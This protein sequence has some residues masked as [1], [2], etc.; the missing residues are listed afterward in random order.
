MLSRGS[1]ARDVSWWAL[2]GAL[3][4]ALRAEAAPLYQLRTFTRRDGLAHDIVRDVLEARDGA[5]WFATPEGVT[6][7]D[8]LRGRYELLRPSQAETTALAEGPDG[9]IWIGT[10][11]AGLGRYRGGRWRWFTRRDGLPSD[12]VKSLLVDR[13]GRLWATLGGG[14][15]IRGDGERLFAYGPAQGLAPGELTRCTELRSG[16]IVCGVHDQ[17]LLQRF[18]GQR[19][20]ALPVRAEVRRHF[21]VQALAEDRD[22]RLWLGTAGAGALAGLLREGSYHFEVYDARRGLASNRVLAIRPARDGRLWLA[23]SGGASRFDGRT[24]SS[25]TRRDGLGSNLILALAEARDGAIWMGTLGGGVTRHAL[26]RWEQMTEADGLASN[27]L[28]GGLLRSRDGALWVGTDGGVCRFAQGRWETFRTGHPDRDY[29][30]HLLEDRRGI[31]WVATRAGIRRRDPD[32][33]WHDEALRPGGRPVGV[34]HLAQTPA[35]E[36]WLATGAGV[37]ARGP[38]GY[39]WYARDRG[40]PAEEANA[41]LVDRGGRV[42]VATDG[43]VARLEN[44]RWIAFPTAPAPERADRVFG[45]AQARDGGLW[46][47]GPSGVY[48]LRGDKWE[49]LPSGPF[50]PP[51]RFSRFVMA[52]SDGSLWFA[53][54]GLGVHRLFDGRWSRY[55]TADGLGS[56]TVHELLTEGDGTLFFATFGGGLSR[57][58]PD[59]LPPETSL[60]RGPSG[61][62]GP[63]SVVV[64]GELASLALGGQ[65][66]LKDTPTADLLYSY[67]VDGGPWSPF[68]SAARVVLEGLRPGVHRVEA[69]AMDRDLNV[70]P[71][72]A[73]HEVRVVRRW[74][75]EPWLLG[76]VAASLGL[77]GY[78]AARAARARG[79]ERAAI[80]E[81]EAVLEQRRH[82]VRLASHELRKPLARLGHRAE[83]L[84]LEETRADP[85]RLAEYAGA[86][87]ADAR[88]LARLVESLLHQSRLAT[89]IP[90]AL[91][92]GDLSGAVREIL[93]RLA[94]DGAEGPPRF[95]PAEAPLPVRYD[96][97]YLELALRNLLDNAAKYAGPLT[98]VVV[99]TRPE[100]KLGVLEVRDAGAGVPRE[101]RERI[102]LP[103]ERGRT[104]PEHG[105]FGLGLGFARE[106]ARAH[107]GELELA[108]SEGK[109]ATFLLSLPLVETPHGPPADH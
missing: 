49:R 39:R 1:F 91:Q 45:L 24:F 50:L 31:V 47:S 8:P 32:G 107:G 64:E 40:L 62:L 59:H 73:R 25:L 77:L 56:D 86:V 17:P 82:F 90:L 2:C 14:G 51:G 15:V 106:I 20:E 4:V 96:P 21:Y 54:R 57:Y 9:A 33:G 68:D 29:V 42:W 79:R 105:G 104:R 23:T 11:G 12:D 76:L 44:E 61:V 46:A 88:H 5:F 63:S 71:T 92:P 94:V 28:T 83:M 27:N 58:R 93:S 102:F 65:D 10:E 18:D 13:R 66:A 37:A 99:A 53:I 81:R 70:D 34:N 72:P 101:D 22:G 69:R 84:T 36:L 87:L 7:Y 80:R 78:A 109:G 43:G 75:R 103:F 26:S 48:R 30:Q 85:A 95:C 67:R 89:G 74:W 16:A 60:G 97:L 38:S 100:G 108:P 55:S 6:R 19:W 3:L 41:L 98:E 35:G 52:T